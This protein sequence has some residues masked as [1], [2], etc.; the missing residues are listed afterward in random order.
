[1]NSRPSLLGPHRLVGA[2]VS[3]SSMNRVHG[4]LHMAVLGGRCFPS[5]VLPKMHAPPRGVATPRGPVPG[6]PR[7]VVTRP[8]F[9]PQSVV[10]DPSHKEEVTPGTYHLVRMAFLQWVRSRG[11]FS[12]ASS[13]GKCLRVLR[14]PSATTLFVIRQ[15]D[16]DAVP[17]SSA[18]QL[19]SAETWLGQRYEY[20][21]SRTLWTG[22]KGC[23]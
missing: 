4:Q 23:N 5:V 18:V 14:S 8:V 16:T 13:S 2:L 19:S 1:M 11:A 20:G 10:G 12:D 21:L 7:R 6:T 15:S 22:V 9:A 17:F 3:V